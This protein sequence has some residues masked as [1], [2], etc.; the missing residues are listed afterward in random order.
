M[1]NS[2]VFKQIEQVKYLAMENTWRYRPIIRIMYHNHLRYKYWHYKEDIYNELKKYPQFKDYTLDNLKN[3][4]DYL[5]ENKNLEVLQDSKKAKTLEEFKNRQFK[6][7]LSQYTIEIERM[8]IE[9]EK[10]QGENKGSLDTDL[11]ETFRKKLESFLE[12]KGAPP[13][14]VYSWWNEI[15]DYFKKINENYQDYIK[16]F[17]TPKV[18]ELMKTMEFITY[19]KDFIKYLKEFIKG[20]QGNIIYLEKIFSEIDEDEVKAL[21]NKVLEHEKTIP[22]LNYKLD[23]GEFMRTNLARWQSIQNWF[24]ST[25]E[26]KS[27]CETILDITN[28]IIMKITR[29]ASQIS[30]RRNSGANRK[31]EYRKLL[32][33]FYNCKDLEEAHKL[34]AVTIGVFS[35][36][37]ILGNPIRETES[38]NSSIFEEKPHQV[39]VKPRT[40]KYRE[41]LTKTPIEDKREQKEKLKRELRERAERERKVIEELIVDNKIVFK[42]LPTLTPFQRNTLLRWLSRA[43]NNKTKKSKTEY[44]REYQVLLQDGEKIT[45]NCQDGILIMPNYILLF[46]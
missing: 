5:V 8:I 32:E 10:L 20:I 2:D 34:S 45:L 21:L 39:V 4:L 7:Q 23:E 31:L 17:Y 41:R 12:I 30:E 44:G 40:R 19:K 22:R 29:Y 26:R 35:T 43:N 16:S 37:H 6:Y 28:E 14:K 11:V 18:E 36:R 9:L 15:S 24:L 46:N 38:I 1:I 3:D 42:D 33:L 27:D 25:E 13:K